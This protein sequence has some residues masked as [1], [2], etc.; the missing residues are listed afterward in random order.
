LAS[1]FFVLP[2]FVSPLPRMF[3]VTE[4]SEAAD[5]DDSRLPPHRAVRDEVTRRRNEAGLQIFHH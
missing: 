2:T 4:M 1:L 5:R 3:L